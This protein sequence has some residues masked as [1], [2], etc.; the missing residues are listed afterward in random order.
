VKCSI[1]ERDGGRQ[2]HRRQTLPI[3]VPSKHF[4]IVIAQVLPNDLRRVRSE[5]D[6][7][8]EIS[9]VARLRYGGNG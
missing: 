2:K 6:T 7:D 3:R 8:D 1:A 5:I 4:K 9:L